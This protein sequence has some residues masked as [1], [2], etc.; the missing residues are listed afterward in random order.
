MRNII[1]NRKMNL[2][3]ILSVMILTMSII[4][5]VLGLTNPI[6]SNR[7]EIMGIGFNRKT[8]SVFDTISLFW[9]TKDY[10]LAIVIGLFVV[11]LP[12]VKYVELAYYMIYKND[13]RR[14]FVNLDRWNMLDVFLV[15]LLLLNFKMNGSAI[16]MDLRVGTAF[17]AAAV[18]TRIIVIMLVD[19][20]YKSNL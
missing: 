16:V 1:I 9:Q 2:I 18:I 17:I 13:C 14:K 4:F 6:L 19:K 8:V 20:Q 12:I 10:L 3:G 11:V 7:I 15:A 5:F